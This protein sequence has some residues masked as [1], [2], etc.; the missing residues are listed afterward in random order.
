MTLVVALLA[1][2]PISWDAETNASELMYGRA[3]TELS[4]NGAPVFLVVNFFKPLGLGP[5]PTLVYNH[6]STGHG[7]NPAYFKILYIA[8][9]LDFFFN[10]RGWL[11]AFP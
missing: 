6:G 5:F 7:A 11:L 8:S 3:P 2:Q 9:S 1:I 10:K 4:E